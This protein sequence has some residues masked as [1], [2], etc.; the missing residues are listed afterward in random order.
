MDADSIWQ[1][2]QQM[3]RGEV[4]RHN[5]SIIL[6]NSAGQD[7][8]RWE[9]QDAFPV[10]WSG[11]DLRAGSAEVAIETLELAHRGFMDTSGRK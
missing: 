4:K 6:M 8:W 11:P 7:K 5:V 3:L 9:F 2:E 1:W 10:R